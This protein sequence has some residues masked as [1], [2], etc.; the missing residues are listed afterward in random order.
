MVDWEA[1]AKQIIADEKDRILFLHYYKDAT[2]Q[3][4]RRRIGD[5]R[6]SKYLVLFGTIRR[7]TNQPVRVAMKN[8][9]TLREAI[10]RVENSDYSASTKQD[11][12]KQMG[13][14]YNFVHEGDRSLKYASKELRRL[15][16]YEPKANEKKAPKPILTREEVR[17][18]VKYGNAFDRAFIFLLYETGARIGEFIGLKK[19]DISTTEEGMEVFISK[20]KT[21]QRRVL[22]V[23]ATQFVNNWLEEHPLKEAN[24]LLWV[25]PATKKQ[26]TDTAIKKRMRAIVE[27]LNADRKKQGIPLFNKPINFHN[28]RHSRAS[29]LGASGSMNEALLC[30][31]FGWEIGSQTPKTYLHISQEKVNKAVLQS[32]G[33]VKPEET[34]VIT[35]RT[36]PRCK[37]EN[38][39]ALHYCGRCGSNLDSGKPVSSFEEMKARLEELEKVVKAQLKG[40]VKRKV[41]KKIRDKK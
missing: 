10:K 33:K 21:G 25:S 28:F 3:T 35:Q 18:L 20:G 30:R 27:R 4:G 2:K 7:A 37:E 31:Y 39:I 9:E 23:E 15:V 14:L 12:I 19:S 41:G 29:E 26:Y 11:S 32:Y 6:V 34:K 16:D 8:M 17:E 1:K 13:S 5:K 40:S 24:T 36:C 22:V 38:S